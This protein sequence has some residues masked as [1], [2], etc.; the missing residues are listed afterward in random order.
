MGRGLAAGMWGPARVR[1]LRVC[2]DVGQPSSRQFGGDEIGGTTVEFRPGDRSAG[3]RSKV[4][5]II[6]E[7]VEIGFEIAK[8]IVIR[9]ELALRGRGRG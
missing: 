5:I 8:L 9:G 1:T 7:L 2:L 3:G 6:T 4:I